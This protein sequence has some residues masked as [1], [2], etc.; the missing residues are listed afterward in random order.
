MA[1]TKFTSTV[2][3]LGFTGPSASSFTSV[4]TSYS[5]TA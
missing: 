4:V 1:P 5:D 3:I 2:V